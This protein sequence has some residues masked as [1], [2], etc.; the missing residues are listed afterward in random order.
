MDLFSVFPN[1]KVQRRL[2]ESLPTLTRNQQ[3]NAEGWLFIAG[4][5]SLVLLVMG[6]PILFSVYISL[7]RADL[8]NIPGEFIGLDNY[9]W[10]LQYDVWWTSVRNVTI[11]GLVLLPTNILFS[12]Y[13]ALFLTERVKGHYIYRTAYLI[14]IAGPPLIWAIVWKFMLFPTEAGFINSW[15]I[16]L[17][18]ESVGWLTTRP[19]ALFSIIISLLW[20]FGISML[21]YLA[22]LSG[23]PQSL[24][25]SAELDGAGR[26]NRL[27]YI[28]WPLLKPTTFFLV[29]VQ[30]INIFQLGF[31]A[32]FVLTEGGPLN[33]TMVPSYFIY[34][35]AF[36]FNAFG[37]S[38]AASLTM[39]VL[40]LVVT[41]L[42]WLPL[43]GQTEY[44]QG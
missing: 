31:A 22:A 2:R 10:L 32:V 16:T 23:I 39:F 4:K 33:S 9:I 17:G 44:Y 24:L 35:L 8:Y 42:L 37:R 36:D 34:T 19:Y 11:I 20:G 12:L 15:L 28:I 29:V 18:F 6:F 21:I 5:M 7:T 26:F 13:T 25:E 40:T 38:A 14:P 3:N 1:E 27:R 30:V 41:L 43:R